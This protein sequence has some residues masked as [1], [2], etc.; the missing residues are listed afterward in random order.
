MKNVKM[1]DSVAEENVEGNVVKSNAFYE[2]YGAYNVLKF[3][4]KNDLR[5]LIDVTK[6]MVR[7][8]DDVDNAEEKEYLEKLIVNLENAKN[9]IPGF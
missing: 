4:A 3:I 8:L 5:K 9:I 2:A 6:T 7:E 1:F